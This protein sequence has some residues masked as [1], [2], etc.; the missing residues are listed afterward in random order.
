M[1]KVNQSQPDRG[2]SRRIREN[3]LVKRGEIIKIPRYA[4]AVSKIANG[5]ILN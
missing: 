4:K 1:G 2:I 5:P 3:N